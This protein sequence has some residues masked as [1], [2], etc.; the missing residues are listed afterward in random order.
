MSPWFWPNLNIDKKTNESMI[1]TI[2]R[3]K[4]KNAIRKHQMNACAY[5][6]QDKQKL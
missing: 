4:L 2:D 5:F 6:G 1:Y 3:E